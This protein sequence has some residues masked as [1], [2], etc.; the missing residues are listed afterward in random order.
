MSTSTVI[1]EPLA[2]GVEVSDLALHIVLADGREISAP[3]AWFPKLLT[4]PIGGGIGIHWPAVDE[5]ISVAQAWRLAFSAIRYC[6]LFTN[7]EW[8]SSTAS[9]YTRD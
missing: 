9:V 2:T 7:R 3:L 6:T 4:L 8:S 5:D 1:R